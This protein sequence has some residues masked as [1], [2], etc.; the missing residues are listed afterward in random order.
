MIGAKSGDETVTYAELIGGRHF[1]LKVDPAA[2]TKNPADYKIVGKP[3]ARLDIPG[4]LT[5]QF[6]YMQD[7]RVPGMLH[8]RVVRPPAIGAKLES[9]DEFSIKRYFRHHQSGA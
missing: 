4:K 8:G 2:R 1:T 6:T 7:F 3:I 5:G 9:V